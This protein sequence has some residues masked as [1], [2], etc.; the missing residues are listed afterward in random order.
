MG[1]RL[2]MAAPAPAGGA[3]SAVARVVTY[4][5]LSS[6]LCEPEHFTACD[7]S[8]LD[9]PM[10]LARVKEQ[11]EPHVKAGAVIGLQEVSA[12]WVGELTPY[13]EERGYT[14][15][16][17]L[18][19]RHFNGYMGVAL[20][21]PSARY[22]AEAVE[23]P[24]VAETKTWP[25][26]P[27]VVPPAKGRL[28]GWWGGVRSWARGLWRK[29][30]PADGRPPFDPLEE[31]AK[32]QNILLSARLRDRASGA[33]FCVSTYHM[34]CLFGSD[35]KVQVMVY[36]A[37]LVARHAADFAAGLPHIVCGDFNFT[38]TSSPYALVTSGSLPE[39]HPQYPPTRS[40][41]PWR[42][43]LDA[44]LESAY[45]TKLGAEPDFTNLATTKFGGGLFCETLDYIFLSKGDWSVRAVKPLQRR[46]A[47]V[48][49]CKSYPSRGEP[50]DHVL[51]W[52][53]LEMRAAAAA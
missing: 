36:H 20:A 9:P 48:P 17:G 40:C 22:A 24:R 29:A 50:S 14:F 37:A 19:G 27:K 49:E 6:H 44:P 45:L 13:F 25:K 1:S 31:A 2:T 33:R 30:P 8:D 18:Y 7:P 5:V 32:R 52:A 35:A 26:P 53:D 10:R 39:T 21:W 28:E 42:P 12:Q 11:L 41:D 43:S 23:L 3:S 4:N 47:V 15:V 46:D 51:I 16:S 38:P 34:P